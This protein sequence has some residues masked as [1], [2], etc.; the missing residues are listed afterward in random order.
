MHIPHDCVHDFW[1]KLF[2]IIKQIYIGNLFNF[3]FEFRM[4]FFIYLFLKFQ[5]HA[6]SRTQQGR[7]KE[8]TVKTLCSPFSMELWRHVRALPRNHSEEMKI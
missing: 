5:F 1:R 3:Y 6:V 7:Q 8:S 2:L 4:V